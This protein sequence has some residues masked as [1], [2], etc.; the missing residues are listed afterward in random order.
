MEHGGNWFLGVCAAILAVGGLFVTARAGQGVGYYGGLAMF[1][2][3]VL[4]VMYLIKVSTGHRD[5]ESSGH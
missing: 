4:F 5:G 3:G 1:A 2:F